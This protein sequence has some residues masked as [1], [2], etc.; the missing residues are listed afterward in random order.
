MPRPIKF[1]MVG[2]HQKDAANAMPPPS[3]RLDLQRPIMIG[4]TLLFWAAVLAG[5][6]FLVS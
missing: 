2:D 4:A 6:R 3:H 1:T 5:I